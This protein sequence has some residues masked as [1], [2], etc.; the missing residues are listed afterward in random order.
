M[1][2][3][4]HDRKISFSEYITS[5]LNEVTYKGKNFMTRVLS[6]MDLTSSAA[7]EKALSLAQKNLERVFIAFG[8][9]ERFDESLVVLAR[10]LGLRNIFYEK[11]NVLDDKSKN[12]LSDLDLEVVTLHNKWDIKLYDFA[13]N[14]FDEK[15]E[16]GGAALR[17]EIDVFKKINGK[18][19]NVCDLIN[20]RDGLVSDGGIRLPKA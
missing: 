19:Q 2:S 6:G 20:K 15:V 17:R 7:C 1:Y 12:V 10:Q 4:I 18:M 16:S 13:V 11:R 9:Q 8:I 14:L 5:D 3:I